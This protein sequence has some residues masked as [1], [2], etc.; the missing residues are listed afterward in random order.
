MHSMDNVDTFAPRGLPGRPVVLEPAVEVG[1]W[2][3]PRH[4]N[5]RDLRANAERLIAALVAVAS[6]EIEIGITIN[7]DDAA[8]RDAALEELEMLLDAARV[9]Q[10][11]LTS[12]MV[13]VVLRDVAR[14]APD[15]A[16]K[17]NVALD[18]SVAAIRKLRAVVAHLLEED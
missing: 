17:L 5:I 11:T 2:Q 9:T 16:P 1:R 13:R 8:K 4:P 14:H 3:Y 10:E 6:D 7:E 12:R 15:I 18:A